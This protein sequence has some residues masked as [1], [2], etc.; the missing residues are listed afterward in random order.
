MPIVLTPPVYSASR[1]ALVAKYS[2]TFIGDDKIILPLFG[3]FQGD[4]VHAVSLFIDN[5][6]NGIPISYQVGGETDY[7]SAY[8]SQ[9]I[10]VSRMDTVILTATDSVSINLALYNVSQSGGKS[11]GL[12]PNGVSDPL[13]S[14]V[15]GLWHFDANNGAVIAV[16]SKNAGK[17]LSGASNTVG[18]ITNADSL[19]GGTSAQCVTGTPYANQHWGESYLPASVSGDYTLEL[20][21]KAKTLFQGTFNLIAA[22]NESNGVLMSLGFFYD[23]ANTTINLVRGSTTVASVA[24]VDTA[25]TF[26]W[27]QI[28]VTTIGGFSLWIDG[29]QRIITVT[30]ANGL[31]G[32]I[33]LFFEGS[34]FNAT[35][36][37]LFVDEM[38]VTLGTRYTKNYTPATTTF[39]NQ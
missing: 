26:G 23:G 28:A 21:V 35:P 36:P 5:Y 22:W 33:D 11:R 18:L 27:H 10:D 3:S 20:A 19:F 17:F 1:G 31:G 34:N 4:P 2:P 39:P 16:D 24:N 13:W 8:T 12:P 7:V 15:V 29:V 30:N 38:R 6:N 37:A 25:N 32:A 9:Y 14:N